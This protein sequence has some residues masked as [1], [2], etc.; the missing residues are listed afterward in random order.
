MNYA[1]ITL[2]PLCWTYAG[3]L[4]DFRWTS[5]ELLHAKTQMPGLTAAVVVLVVVL[6]AVA[7]VVVIIIIVVVVVVE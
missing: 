6:V 7:V 1:G 3:F 5:A 2:D 4:L